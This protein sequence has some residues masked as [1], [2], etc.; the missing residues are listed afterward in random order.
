MQIL[1]QT[2]DILQE[3][4]SN[5]SFTALL[6]DAEYQEGDAVRFLTDHPGFYTIMLDDTLGKASLLL[7]DTSFTW[8]VPF[9]LLRKRYNPR[10]FSGTRHYI[11]AE[12]I[13]DNH[14]KQQRILSCNIYDTAD[15]ANVYPHAWS[16]VI[17]PEKPEFDAQNAIDG[18]IYPYVHGRYPYES[19]G[20]NRREDA[21]WHLNFGR[22]IQADKIR[23]TLR[24]DF[25]H[26]SYW[27]AID[28]DLSNGDHFDL[29]FIKT[30]NSQEFTMHTEP[31]Q[32]LTLS[33]F[34]RADDSSPFPA[35][36]QIEVIGSDI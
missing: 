33:H 30:G 20:I 21:E 16:N 31:F 13:K 36:T 12:T 18:I 5:S 8:K 25:P 29:H 22:K 35:L 7:T 24:S 26:D 10:A 6:Y 17:T 28:L 1:N 11:T 23:I 32:Q 2:G 34:Q 19:W 3:A 4:D 27:N 15:T 9:G 14:L